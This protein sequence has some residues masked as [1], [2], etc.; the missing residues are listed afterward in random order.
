MNHRSGLK[1][2]PRDSGSSRNALAAAIGVPDPART[3]V[4]VA[5]VVLR[6]GAEWAGLE[7]DLIALVRDRISPHV[8]PRRI[9][10]A[11][12]LPMTATGKI[13]RRALREA[14]R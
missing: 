1:G 13:M 5:H 9:I 12:A 4:V 3:E 10:R 2:I 6:D 7:R 14:Y 8:A 11:D